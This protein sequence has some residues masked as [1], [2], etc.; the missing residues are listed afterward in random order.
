MSDTLTEK[1]K[2]WWPRRHPQPIRSYKRPQPYRCAVCK[3][4]LDEDQWHYQRLVALSGVDPDGNTARSFARENS[5]IAC[6]ERQFGC[7]GNSLASDNETN[8]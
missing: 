8:A 4:P 7:V 2:R 1:Q 5:H 6:Y 3:Q